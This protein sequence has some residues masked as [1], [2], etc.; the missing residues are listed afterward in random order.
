VTLK[1]GTFGKRSRYT[2]EEIVKALYFVSQ[3]DPGWYG[4]PG[5]G[6]KYRAGMPLPG[7]KGVFIGEEVLT[8]K[9]LPVSFGL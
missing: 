7:G 1:S 8:I 4:T 3:G 5:F 9:F 2:P 6:P